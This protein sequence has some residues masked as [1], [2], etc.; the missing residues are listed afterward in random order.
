MNSQNSTHSGTA[1]KRISP[2]R[3]SSASSAMSSGGALSLDRLQIGREWR[4]K[5]DA[6]RLA[7]Y[8]RG[9][10]CRNWPDIVS[11]SS[12]AIPGSKR[13]VIMYACRGYSC[14]TDR[15]VDACRLT[16]RVPGLTT[17]DG[18]IP[19]SDGHRPP[20]WVVLLEG[21]C[22]GVWRPTARREPERPPRRI[23]FGVERQR[24]HKAM[25]IGIV[26][27]LKEEMWNIPRSPRQIGNNQSFATSLTL[28]G[29]ALSPFPAAPV[30]LTTEPCMDEDMMM[31]FY[32]DMAE[33]AGMTWEE[34]FELKQEAK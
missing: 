10:V 28:A 13:R 24:V 29:A 22:D 9:D 2:L 18:A 12:E 23:S 25:Q 27:P 15:I 16:M 20:R 30:S 11:D 21:R 1:T 6:G 19:L 26:E 14:K 4:N 17:K 5:Q 34:Y 8:Y 33:L 3:I 32:R 31:E 7:A